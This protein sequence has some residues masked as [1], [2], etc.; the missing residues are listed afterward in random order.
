M[1][2]TK[3]LKKHK[4]NKWEEDERGT[5]TQLGIRKGKYIILKRTCEDC[6]FIEFKE[7]DK[8]F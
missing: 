1:R 2:C 4:F 6:G 8:Y 7:I 5:I 3:F